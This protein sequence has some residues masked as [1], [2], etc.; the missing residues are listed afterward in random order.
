MR[1]GRRRQY[2]AATAVVISIAFHALVL[3]YLALQSPRLH[4]PHEEAG[5]PEP[6]I[7]VLIMPRTPPAAG[8]SQSR[9]EPIRLHRRRL[10]TEAAPPPV[11]PLITPVEPAKPAP[12]PPAAHKALP[13]GAT[14]QPTPNAQLST[15]LRSGAVGCANPELLSPAER[16]RCEEQLG[17]GVATA[18]TLGLGLSAAK[19]EELDRQSEHNA[20]CQ[21][22]RNGGAFP[23]L[24]NGPC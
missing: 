11:P 5:P 16:A 20:A 18:P 15:V 14:V 8:G 9:P 12:A 1:D 7:P 21:A 17:R 10:R 2:A 24:R 23:G 3:T 22:Y 4:P 19:Q 13:R 6:I